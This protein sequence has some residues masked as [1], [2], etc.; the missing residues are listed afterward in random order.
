[1]KNS[2]KPL[3]LFDEL[4]AYIAS[5]Y[6]STKF[7]KIEKTNNSSQLIVQRNP[8]SLF[9]A[10]SVKYLLILK[11]TNRVMFEKFFGKKSPNRKNLNLL[12]IQAEIAY[13]EWKSNLTLKQLSIV[14]GDEW[15][16]N[17]Y[18]TLKH[19]LNF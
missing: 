8:L 2:Q 9:L 6:I 4:N 13:T 18:I 16:F 11:N 14:E 15:F 19:Q 5:M 1:M 7:M 10:Y 12:F 3:M 17:E